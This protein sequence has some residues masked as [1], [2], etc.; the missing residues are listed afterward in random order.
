MQIRSMANSEPKQESPLQPALKPQSEVKRPR[1]MS[2]NLTL[3]PEDWMALFR[4]LSEF[5]GHPG[6]AL[7]QTKRDAPQ[8]VLTLESYIGHFEN[9][10]YYECSILFSGEAEDFS[11]WSPSQRREYRVRALSF[12]VLGGRFEP[13][14]GMIGATNL[15]GHYYGDDKPKAAF[16]RA[17]KRLSRKV[18]T[19]QVRL[20]NRDGSVYNENGRGVGYRF[21]FAA[22]RWAQNGS[23]RTLDHYAEPLPEWTFPEDHPWY[24]DEP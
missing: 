8:A 20:M 21:G 6:W 18:T 15:L 4:G 9:V 16:L 24:Q 3:H 11:G 13:D 7:V 2:A 14:E 1:M 10:P 23:N 17:V 12:F 19:D 22:L 5:T